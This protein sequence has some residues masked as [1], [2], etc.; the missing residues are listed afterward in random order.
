MGEFFCT[1]DNYAAAGKNLLGLH[2][3]EAGRM[4]E[5]VYEWKESSFLGYTK[6][7]FNLALCY[8]TG[9]GVKKDLKQAAKH[10]KLAAEDDHPQAVYNLALMYINGE[11]VDTD[12]KKGVELMEKAA[13]L[14]LSQVNTKDLSQVNHQ[15]LLTAERIY[16]R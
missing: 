3:A 15:E 11:V 7:N 14:D 5:A 9:K 16:H 13:Q 4:K 1:C 8:E 10:Y 12:M 6:A 2:R